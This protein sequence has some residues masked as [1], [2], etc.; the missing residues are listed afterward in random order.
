MSAA[1]NLIARTLKKQ[2]LNGDLGPGDRP[3]GVC[4]SKPPANTSAAPREVPHL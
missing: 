1:P 3:I 2:I 4:F